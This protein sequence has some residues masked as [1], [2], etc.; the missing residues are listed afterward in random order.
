MGNMR[1]CRFE[2][3]YHDLVDCYEALGEEGV[4]SLVKNANQYEKKYITKL[5]KLC[6]DI[7]ADF[8]EEA[9][10]EVEK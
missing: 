10:E 6:S 1:H 4:D 8:M 2:N 5:I 7:A 9:E 3:T